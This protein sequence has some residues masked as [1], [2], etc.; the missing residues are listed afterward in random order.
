[1]ATTVGSN[2]DNFAVENIR[3]NIHHRVLFANKINNMHLEHNFGVLVAIFWCLALFLSVHE[4]AAAESRMTL[5]QFVL[6]HFGTTVEPETATASMAGNQFSESELARFREIVETEIF[7]TTLAPTTLA[8]TTLAP[9]TLA[10]TTTKV[11]ANVSW[12]RISAIYIHH[13]PHFFSRHR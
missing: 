10:P 11:F 8:P 9:T 13:I 12:N 7:T 2:T 6:T 1:M 3:E 5:E 4:V